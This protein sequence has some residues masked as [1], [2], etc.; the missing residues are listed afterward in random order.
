MSILSLS[1]YIYQTL[2]CYKHPNVSLKP[3][4]EKTMHQQLVEKSHPDQSRAGQ[5]KGNEILDC[6]IGLIAGIVKG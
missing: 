6:P 2:N 1:I 3:A 4:V 5:P